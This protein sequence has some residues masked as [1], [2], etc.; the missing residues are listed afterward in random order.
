MNMTLKKMFMDFVLAALITFLLISVMLPASPAISQSVGGEI[1]PQPLVFIPSVFN[2]HTTEELAYVSEPVPPNADIYLSDSDGTTFINLSNT[3]ECL[4]YH[5][6][7]SPDSSKIAYSSF[8]NGDY[9][10]YVMNSD[11]SGKNRLTGNMGWGYSLTWSMDGSQIAFDSLLEGNAD[12]Y[13][14][15]ADGSELKKL[16]NSPNMDISPSWSPVD[17]NKIVFWCEVNVKNGICVINSDGS[18]LTNLTEG[19]E[20]CALR[21]SVSAWSPDGTKILFTVSQESNINIYVMNNDGTGITN[22][23]NRPGYYSGPTWSPDGTKIAFDI[24]IPFQN[25]GGIGVINIDGSGF[26]RLTN[27]INNVSPVW[28]PDGTMIAFTNYVGSNTEVY[29]MNSD[30]SGFRNISNRLGGDYYPLWKP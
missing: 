11:G 8:C 23:T 6:A 21:E 3:P 28:S 2:N 4:E 1:P 20:N 14:V 30:G 26:K 24:T 13:V 27:S 15:K 7:W 9:G 16:T 17:P 12:I 22:I 19:I 5:F 29:I 25:E 18:G 10:I